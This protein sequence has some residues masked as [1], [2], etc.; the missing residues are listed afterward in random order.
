[1]TTQETSQAND[2]NTS[3]TG[4]QNTPVT[5]F[6]DNEG[7]PSMMRIISVA[8]VLAAI[9]CAATIGFRDTPNVGAMENLA[10]Y[11]LIAGVGGKGAQ[12]MIE[13]KKG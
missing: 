13:L 12:K 3:Q 1:M 8:C 7:N 2:Q 9:G 6:T 5:T 10:L 4:N 11:F